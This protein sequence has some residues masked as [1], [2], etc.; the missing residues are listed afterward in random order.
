MATTL[1]PVLRLNN[2]NTGKLWVQCKMSACV[3]CALS[4]ERIPVDSLIPEGLVA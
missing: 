4:V 3:V 2:I 1:I